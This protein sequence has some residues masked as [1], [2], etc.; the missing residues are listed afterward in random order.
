M[1]K[2]QIYLFCEFPDCEAF[3]EVNDDND[4][5]DAIF[6][7]LQFPVRRF[8][9]D[10]HVMNVLNFG[11]SILYLKKYFIAFESVPER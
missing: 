1:K 7:T 11:F 4:K 10:I 2:W 3:D 9:L 5:W 6:Q 8:F